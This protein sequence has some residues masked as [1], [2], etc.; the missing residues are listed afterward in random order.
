M[1]V[2]DALTLVKPDNVGE[3][4]SFLSAMDLTLSGL[5]APN[6]RLWM[7]RDEGGRIIGSTGYELSADHRHAL[8]RSVAVDPSGRTAGKGS[9]LAR[10]ALDHAAQEGA[11]TAWLFSRRSGPFWQ[12]LGFSPADKYELAR[13]LGETHQ[14]RLFEQTGQLDNE[15]AWSRALE[16]WGGGQ[17]D[18]LSRLR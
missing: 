14:V 10:F 8:V 11:S 12:K 13:L 6:I 16:T 18:E 9:D 7:E 3:L 17:A 5:S 1:S 2:R 15:V 4:T